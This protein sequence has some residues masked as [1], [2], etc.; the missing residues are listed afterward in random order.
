MLIILLK[1]AA[2][3]FL[4]VLLIAVT[5]WMLGRR[6]PSQALLKHDSLILIAL[7]KSDPTPVSLSDED[8]LNLVWRGRAA[9]PFIASENENWDEFLLLSP[10]SSFIQQLKETNQFDDVFAVKLKLI[11]VPAF[12]LGL[13]RLR[14]LSGISRMKE[15]PMLEVLNPE[16]ALRPGILPSTAALT[17]AMS[18]RSDMA[19][20]MMNFLQYKADAHGNRE[21][22]RKIYNRYGMEAMKAVHQVGG[23]FLF[24]G[25]ITQVLIPSRSQASP[26]DWDDLA[27]M[28]YPNPT[29]IFLMEQ[30]EAY[31]KA[32]HLRDQSL[33]RTV[34]IA[35]EAG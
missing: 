22:G 20:T 28:I 2:F 30:N 8:G 6:Q 3:L 26:N 18:A 10:D 32:L 7:K 25:Q 35:T 29:A 17:A 4:L 16:L 33:E 15:T 13:L 23:Q 27:A 1:I 21:K 24:S 31:R 5:V 12:A 11:R 14:Y 34:V 9:F 19:I